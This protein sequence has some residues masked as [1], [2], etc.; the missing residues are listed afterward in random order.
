MYLNYFIGLP[1]IAARLIASENFEI[2][3]SDSHS[4]DYQ[5]RAV[6]L[7]V[8]VFAVQFHFI[9]SL[10]FFMIKVSLILI[11]FTIEL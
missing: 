11:S 7:I 5:L 2:F 3:Y 10:D 4:D 9:V 8:E 6:S 1:K